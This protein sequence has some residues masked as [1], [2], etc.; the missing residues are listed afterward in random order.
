MTDVALQRLLAKDEIEGRMLAYARAVDR[1]DWALMRETFH[2]DAAIHHAEY[3][4]DVD[5]LVEVIKGRQA[6][7]TITLHV[8]TNCLVEFPGPVTAISDRAVAET[9]LL[10][11]QWLDQAGARTRGV[12]AELIG[13]EVESWG[14]YVDVF[15]RRDGAWRVQRRVTVFETQNLRPA[16]GRRT[17]GPSWPQPRADDQDPLWVARRSVGLA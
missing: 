2:P 15:E 10:A 8:F 1:R 13:L 12:D 16:T 7:V 4:G 11:H 14:R 3:Q 17:F 5:G 9:Y 6:G